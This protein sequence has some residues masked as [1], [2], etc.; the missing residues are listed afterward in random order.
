MKIHKVNFRRRRA[1]CL[2]YLK[3]DDDHHQHLNTPT[4]SHDHHHHVK[5]LHIEQPYLVSSS[6][7]ILPLA[8]GNGHNRPNSAASTTS[9]IIAHRTNDGLSDCESLIQSN[10]QTQSHPNTDLDNFYEEI[11]EQQQQTAL[12]LGTNGNKGDIINPYL[13]AKSLFQDSKSSQPIRDHHEVFYYEY[14]ES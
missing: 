4:T 7:A 9:S 5:A 8:S 10:G 2:R 14:E 1:R 13:E 11:K 3:S 12:A 6:P